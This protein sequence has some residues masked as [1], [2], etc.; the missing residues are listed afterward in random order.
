[1]TTGVQSKCHQRVE[2]R[3]YERRTLFLI[4]QSFDLRDDIGRHR[5]HRSAEANED[6]DGWGI[7]FGLQHADVLAS[8]LGPC[9]DLLL[10]EAGFETQ[11]FE[12]LSEHKC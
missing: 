10:C 3:I 6:F 9:R 8:D 2:E 5:I 7:P 12:F 1:M 4:Q 11:L